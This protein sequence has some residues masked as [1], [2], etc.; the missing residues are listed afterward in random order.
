MCFPFVLK[1]LLITSNF[2][3]ILWL[4]TSFGENISRE[5]KK[6]IQWLEL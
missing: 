2:Y 1:L 5:E 3:S 6:E 4:I